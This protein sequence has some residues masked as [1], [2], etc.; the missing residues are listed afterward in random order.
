MYIGVSSEEEAGAPC[1]RGKS[2]R[3]NV[4]CTCKGCVRAVGM[5]AALGRTGFLPKREAFSMLREGVSSV[6]LLSKYK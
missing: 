1:R 3:L 4:L 5:C 6:G 2:A